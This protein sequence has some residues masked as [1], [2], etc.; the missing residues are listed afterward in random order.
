LCIEGSDAEIPVSTCLVAGLNGVGD[1]V[2]GR[3]SSGTPPASSGE[4]RGVRKPAIN[5]RGAGVNT[6]DERAEGGSGIVSAMTEVCGR[7]IVQSRT[8]FID[9]CETVV[10]IPGSNF[11]GDAEVASLGNADAGAVRFGIADAGAV[12]FPAV[13]MLTVLRGRGER[14]D[15]F[16]LDRERAAG[17]CCVL[18]C[19]GAGAVDA[20]AAGRAAAGAA[21]PCR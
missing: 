5:G 15:A 13:L 20:L 8:F 16:R 9:C 2:T 14:R 17:A 11:L 3:S 12:S 19:G 21:A 1:A 10:C 6:C 4:L 18:L 7:E